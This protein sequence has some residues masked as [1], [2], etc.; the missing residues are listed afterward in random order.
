M[1]R[2][3]SGTI[4]GKWAVGI[5]SSSTPSTFHPTGPETCFSCPY[6][7]ED[8]YDEVDWW[9]V[10]ANI[11]DPTTW[12]TEEAHCMEIH[13]E[14]VRQKKMVCYN[15]RDDHLVYE[16]IKD[17]HYDEVKTTYDLMTSTFVGK[18]IIYAM[19]DFNDLCK[20]CDD[21]Y[22]PNEEPLRPFDIICRAPGVQHHEAL[23]HYYKFPYCKEMYDKMDDRTKANF[24]EASRSRP[25]DLSITG[26]PLKPVCACCK[27]IDETKFGY[28]RLD[29]PQDVNARGYYNHGRSWNVFR[30]KGSEWKEGD[31]F[32]TTGP[33]LCTHC[34]MDFIWD[35]DCPREFREYI[36]YP[37]ATFAY[38]ETVL[39]WTFG[40]QLM[41]ALKHGDVFI[42]SE[43]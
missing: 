15:E 18:S 10:P 31:R 19:L 4:N 22:G 25:I 29:M 33:Y 17:E 39:T 6:G 7:C 12:S 2:W 24:R 40:T 23:L 43:T 21:K 30:F 8:G 5:M 41:Q 16:F 34:A 3:Y 27:K 20:Y 9:E 11:D 28:S 32:S 14:C 26:T 1:G 35:E 37:G 13:G 38:H 36:Y 42:E